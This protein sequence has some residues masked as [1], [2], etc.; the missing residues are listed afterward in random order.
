MARAGEDDFDAGGLLRARGTGRSALG[1]RDSALG[2]LRGRGTGAGL[3]A[4]A[5]SRCG[6]AGVGKREIGICAGGALTLDSLGQEKNKNRC[7]QRES[8]KNGTR[9][10]DV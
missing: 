5:L 10:F 2:A 3:A 1:T 4:C 6:G 8:K 7:K 9:V